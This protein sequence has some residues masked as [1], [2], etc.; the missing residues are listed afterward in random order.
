MS[1]HDRVQ[2]TLGFTI[3]ELLVVVSIIALLIGIL[4]PAIQ[5]ARDAARITQSRS[6]LRNIGAAHAAYSA[7][8]SDRQWTIV[9][10]DM[11]AYGATGTDTCCSPY[12]AANG[13][14]PST[15]I[16]YMS[17]PSA[18]GGGFYLVLLNC[19][20]QGITNPNG[21]CYG[22]EY[23]APMNI[24]GPGSVPNVFAAYRV[25]NCANFTTYMN[26]RY[27]DPVF[28]APKD[29]V[30]LEQCELGFQNPG[31]MSPIPNPPPPISYCMSSAAMFSP[32]FFPGAQS[33]IGNGVDGRF[34][35][36]PA[37]AAQYSDLKTRCLEHNWLQNSQADV[38]PQI[39]GGQTPYFYTASITSAPACLFFDGHVDLVGVFDAMDA[40]E[41]VTAQ[42]GGG[43][44]CKK[45]PKFLA[46]GYFSNGSPNAN[47]AF[48]TQAS[49]GFHV[50]TVNGI[51]GRDVSTSGGG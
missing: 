24:W 42:G 8:F 10:D 21:P 27:Y 35:S 43:L 15:L 49:T 9:P 14:L 39:G 6:N 50:F 18:M 5:K 3:I 2:R 30:L 41:R 19:P 32:D 48:D 1:R 17:D 51:L 38:N 44:W 33:V 37:G 12:L 29:K 13:C 25:F 34:R 28:W 4:L 45:V 22:A 40:D 20:S 16:G 11:G 26:N 31:G 36:P 46:G 23:M 7:D 47:L